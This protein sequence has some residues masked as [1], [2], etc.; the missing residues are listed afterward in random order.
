VATEK[1]IRSEML[2]DD[3]F[4]NAVDKWRRGQP[5]LSNRSEAIRRLV[6]MRLASQQVARRRS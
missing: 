2:A 4:L 3:A 6:E 1:L 5:D